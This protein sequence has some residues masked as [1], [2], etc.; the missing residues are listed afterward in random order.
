MTPS[1]GLRYAGAAA[2]GALIVLLHAPHAAAQLPD[3]PLKSFAAGHSPILRASF[4]PESRLFAT[5]GGANHAVLWDADTVDPA[6]PVPTH[7]F[8]DAGHSVAVLALA[9]SADGLM[10]ATGAGDNANKVWYVSS[11]VHRGDYNGG[12]QPNDVAFSVDGQTLATVSATGEFRLWDIS[13][14]QELA[15]PSGHAGAVRSVAFSPDGLSV[16]TGGIDGYVKVWAAADGAP[17]RTLLDAVIH[18][19]GVE[20][21]TFSAA[22]GL[23]ATQGADG[24]IQVW[25]FA[26]DD[27][28][29]TLPADGGHATF[30]PDGTLIA[31]ATGDDVTMWNTSD[32]SVAGTLTGHAAPPAGLSFSTDAQRFISGDS[33]GILN[34]WDFSTVFP[35]G[36]NIAVDPP[37]VAIGD[38]KVGSSGADAFTVSSAGTETLTVSDITSD[39][40]AFTVAPDTLTLPFDLAAADPDLSETVTVTFSPTVEGAQA[41]NITIVHNAA[42]SPTIVSVAGTGAPLL[43]SVTIGAPTEGQVFPPFT[44]VAAFTVD[45]VDHPASGAWAWQLDTPFPASGPAGGTPVPA[46]TTS[47][48]IPNLVDGASHT[49]YATLVD[50]SGSVLA[51]PAEDSVSFS[52]DP[53]PT[54]YV[55]VHSKQGGSGTTVTIPIDIHIDAYVPETQGVTGVDLD[56]L[57]DSTVLTPEGAGTVLTA[58]TPG[59][60]IVPASWVLEQHIPT[61]GRLAISLAGDTE[62][63][64][65]DVGTL[66]NVT[67][68]VDVAAAAGAVVSLSIDG[69]T[70]NDGTPAATAVDGQFTVLDIVVG[71]VSG[72]GVVSAYD[73][74]HVLSYV[75][76]AGI[77]GTYVFPIEETAPVWA[78]LPVEAQV[79]FEVAD[80]D[81]DATIAAMDAA[82]ILKKRVGIIDL[83]VAEGGQTAP[84]SDPVAL[85]YELRA[86]ATSGRPGSRITVTL[87]ASAIDNLHAG[88][89]TLDYDPSLLRP[90]DVGLGSAAHGRAGAPLLAQREGEG[91]LA[92][93]FASARPIAGPNAR[94]E[95]TFEVS[96]G[97]TRAFQSAIRASHLRLN[98]SRMQTE[99]IHPFR[100]EP[101]QTRLMA[102]YPK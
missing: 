41:A 14:V 26:T 21:I 6:S 67:F 50:D 73:A 62:A 75:V 57:Y 74:S 98:G 86:E 97:L 79:A 65:T 85:V 27:P 60:T 80:V 90:L 28:L 81:D 52:V 30:S 15:A 64:L 92:I 32:G 4:Q 89:L 56:L 83:F 61:A 94:V 101:F 10:I 19:T 59:E 91:R 40:A 39:N 5:V 1:I 36:P 44:T 84:S 46:G 71:D 95:V 35:N 55:R 69:L 38:V 93:G 23:L 18:A 48:T 11:G 17:D 3:V 99:F 34:I 96:R 25:D 12:T 63:P 77:G 37:S 87:D 49:V 78:P 51:T 42:D 31:G 9:F 47:T 53:T 70:L 76:E 66:L 7:E 33:S 8:T 24:V 22:G 43:T 102:N 58:A 45:I 88:E 29:Y 100:V 68:D 54:D 82:D 72:N 2:V 16:L 20:T 13:L